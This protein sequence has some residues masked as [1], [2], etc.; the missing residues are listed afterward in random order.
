MADYLVTL[1]L[2]PVQSMI[3]AARRTRDLWCGSWLL[4]EASRAAAQV[5]YQDAQGGELIFPA[6]ED[7]AWELQPLDKPGDEANI[8]NILR[9]LVRDCDEAQVKRLCA[10]AKAAAVERLRGLGE[11]GQRKHQLQTVLQQE[12]WE[13]QIDDF[14]EGFSA[15][16]RIEPETETGYA[17]AS[18]R[19]GGVLAARKATRD[20]GPAKLGSG[21]YG[22]PKSSLDG[23]FETVLPE[24][25]NITLVRK[26]GLSPGEQ[27]DALGVIK[28]TAGVAEQFTA[29][30]R[31]AADPWLQ[32]LTEEQL[33]RLKRDYAELQK[34]GLATGT[35]GNLNAYQAFPYDAQML[36]DFRLQSARREVALEAAEVEAL[37]QLA[38][39][40]RALG[41]ERSRDGTR[42]GAAV[43]YAAILQADGDR[44]G[45]L[46][47]QAKSAA[48]SREI[49]QALHRFANAV[50]D[51]VRSHRGHAIYSGGDDVLALVPLPNAQAC[52]QALALCFKE[53]MQAVAH[54]LGVAVPTLSVGI[55]IGHIMQPLGSLLARAK[56]AEKLAKGNGLPEEKQQRNALVITLGV[57]SGGDID[58]RTQWN[59]QVTLEELERF[60]ADYRARRLPSRVAYDLRAIHQRMQRGNPAVRPEDAGMRRAEVARMLDRARLQGGGNER[61]DPEVQR[62]LE[63]R[64]EQISLD[65]LANTLIIARWLGARSRAELERNG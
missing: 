33:E 34:L 56:R 38:N 30:S 14:L 37:A 60:T 58:W 64:A 20:F 40:L 44:M 15:W 42:I 29:Y 61:I 23:A 41:H 9:V 46:L 39:T 36:F 11:L 19:L 12:R 47:A 21:G 6:P 49:S 5:F 63:Q 2:G 17:V 45:E 65:K 25:P 18:Q 62:Y 48:E 8:S 50:R 59:D 4:S 1:S 35:S 54:K 7:P 53:N 57:R 43:P 28:R 13:A 3:G 26:L 22:V 16:V 55:G 32:R 24:R 27:L 10:A 51:L 52:A 31:I